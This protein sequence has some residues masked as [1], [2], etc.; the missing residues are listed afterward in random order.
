MKLIHSKESCS[1]T[2]I[3]RILLSCIITVLIISVFGC[4]K[5]VETQKVNRIDGMYNLSKVEYNGFVFSA[6]DEWKGTFFASRSGENIMVTLRLEELGFSDYTTGYLS[7][8]SKYGDEIVYKFWVLS[9][10]GEITNG[11]D[12]NIAYDSIND[13]IMFGEKRDGQEIFHYFKK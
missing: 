3:K 13:E 7:E 1:R 11:I 2:I 8:V 9:H 4:G 12:F 6:D 5:R 10:T